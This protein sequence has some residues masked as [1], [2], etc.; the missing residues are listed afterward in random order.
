LKAIRASHEQRRQKKPFP[1]PWSFAAIRVKSRL[2][3]FRAFRI[4]SWLN[5]PMLPKSAARKLVR[6]RLAGLAPE[7]IADASA[8]ICAKIAHLPGWSEARTVALFAALPGEPDLAALWLQA[9]GKTVCYPRVAGEVMEFYSV[10]S[11]DELAQGAWKVRE[12]VP[13]PSRRI[14]EPEIDLICVPGLA[15]TA[16][17]HRLGR[18]RG[19]YDRFLAHVEFCAQK[20]G[21]CFESQV[22]PAFEMLPH[23]HPVDLLLTEAR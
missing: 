7:F 2:I 11:H 14:R 6:E 1:N 10:D 4:F 22:L 12:P 17:G 23:D 18:G 15:F 9:A 21:V 19:Y 8:R 5:R 3:C 20:V 16:D 13:E